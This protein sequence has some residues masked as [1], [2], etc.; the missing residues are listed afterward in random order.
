MMTNKERAQARQSYLDEMGGELF[1]TPKDSWKLQLLLPE[2]DLQKH[3][4]TDQ[5]TEELFRTPT[6]EKSKDPTLLYGQYDQLALQI[7][8]DDRPGIMGTSNR[9][10]AHLDK[11]EYEKRVESYIEA[12]EKEEKELKVKEEEFDLE[13]ILEEGTEDDISEEDDDL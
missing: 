10:L 1:I 13:D 8:S 5:Q 12:S 11:R 2:Y 9:V 6:L 7:G 3:P 4:M